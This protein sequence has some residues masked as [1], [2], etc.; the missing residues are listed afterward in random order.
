[1]NLLLPAVKTGV[2][3]AVRAVDIHGDRW[4]DLAI[5]LDEM[6]GA[7]HA[8]RV[9]ATECPEGLVAGDRVRVRFVMG[10]MMRVERELA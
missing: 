7:G 10:Q 2:V 3:R 6:P 8:G 1:M 9:A 5:E 4:V